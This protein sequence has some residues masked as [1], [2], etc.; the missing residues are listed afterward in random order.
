MI[1]SHLSQL[2]EQM[3]LPPAIVDSKHELVNVH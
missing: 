3:Q 2:L 1:S